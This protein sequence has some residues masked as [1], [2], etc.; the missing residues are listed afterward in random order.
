MS[1]FWYNPLNDKK[2]HIIILI[3]FF[4]SFIFISW[5]LITLQYYSGFCHTIYHV[6]IG[7]KPKK[8]W[9][10]HFFS[11]E[12]CVDLTRLKSTCSISRLCSNLED[13][14]NHHSP[15][16]F[17]LIE[18]SFLWLMFSSIFKASNCFQIFLTLYQSYTD[19]PHSS[20]FR[21]SMMTLW[22]PKQSTTISLL[23]C[24]LITRFNWI[25]NL[26]SSLHLNRNWDWLWT[27]LVKNIPAMQET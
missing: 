5:R 27:F 8:I 21:N 17:Q 3:F 4:F 11:S 26:N 15:W 7:L 20:I 1:F 2:C 23:C 9:I 22:P 18:A 14:W 24:P 25:C 16:L 19:S 12:I 10:L 6:F 13:Q